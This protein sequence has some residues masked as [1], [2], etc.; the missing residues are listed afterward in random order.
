MELEDIRK[1]V[2]SGKTIEEVLEKFDWR[3]FERTVGDIFSSNG[4]RTFMNFRFKTERRY[5]ID[6]VAVSGSVVFLV[7]CKDWGKGRDKTSGLRS[8]VEKQENRRKE[9]ANERTVGKES[10]QPLAP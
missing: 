9:F 5:E 7:D 3:S 10:R 1:Y 4:Y 8:A 6:V 2:Y